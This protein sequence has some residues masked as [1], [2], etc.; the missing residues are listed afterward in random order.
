[1]ESNGPR[2]DPEKQLVAGGW[3]WPLAKATVDAFDYAIGLKDGTVIRF[4]SAE[5]SEDMQWVTIT[6]ARI[7][8]VV[9]GSTEPA[10]TFSFAR[11]L[12]IRVSEIVWACDAPQGS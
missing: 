11:G 2:T 7:D 4:E 1:M 12:V 6:P 10:D 3:P 8:V 9:W 5:A